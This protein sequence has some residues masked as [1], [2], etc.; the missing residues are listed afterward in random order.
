ME[1][2]KLRN[3]ALEFAFRRT[4]DCRH[5]PATAQQIIQDARQFEEYLNGAPSNAPECD[6]CHRRACG[7]WFESCDGWKMCAKCYKSFKEAK[8][9]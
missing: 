7:A 6:A 8:R 2:E 3:A 5:D 1:G 4:R 9:A